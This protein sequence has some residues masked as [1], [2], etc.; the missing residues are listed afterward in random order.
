MRESVR[1]LRNERRRPEKR[2]LRA[3]KK[4]DL[5]FAITG[6]PVITV[7]RASGATI[8]H[9]MYW[10]KRCLGVSFRNF[11]AIE[12]LPLVDGAYIIAEMYLEGFCRDFMLCIFFEFTIG[13]WCFYHC[14]NVSW[15][16]CRDRVCC[17]FQIYYLQT[18]HLFEE[19]HHE[20]CVAIII[21][22]RAIRCIQFQPQF[23]H[24]FGFFLFSVQ[25]N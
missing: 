24:I 15:W 16:F 14:G 8:S 19:L 11:H 9:L 21:I 12:N 18:A 25:K 5:R 22:H 17:V 3:N 4:R 7:Y 20:G 10:E 6:Q 2:Y 1:R 13:R 23:Y